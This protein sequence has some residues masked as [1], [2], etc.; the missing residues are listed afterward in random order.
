MLT[1]LRIQGFKSWRDTGDLRLAPITAIFGPNS[2]GKSSILQFLLMLKQTVESTDNGTPLNLGDDRSLVDLGVFETVLHRPPDGSP[3]SLNSNRELSFSIDYDALIARRVSQGT[4]FTWSAQTSA[5]LSMDA[6]GAPYLKAFR[7]SWGGTSCIV[8]RSVENNR[9]HPFH[10]QIASEI[11]ERLN[12][13]IMGL[14]EVIK[15]YNL[16]SSST[17]R[18]ERHTYHEFSGVVRSFE[19]TFRDLHYLGPLRD[20]PRRPYPWGGS[21]PS[22]LGSMG[23]HTVSAIL[24]DARTRIVSKAANDGDSPPRAPLETSVA[25]WL[26]KLG[27]ADEFNIDEVAK[28]TNLYRV[29]VRPVSSRNKVMVTDVGFGV[30]QVL[31]VLALAFFGNPDAVCLIEQP[32]LHLHPAVQSHLADLFIDAQESSNKQFI[33]ESHSEHLLLRFQRRIAEGRI[34]PED[35]ALYF[36]EM[37]DGESRISELK[38]DEYGNIANWPKDF[39]GDEFGE[40]AAITKAQMTRR[41]EQES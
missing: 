21:A 27:I 28:G 8:T 35:V 25:L 13:Y 2:S 29:W 6:L 20:R 7:H 16:L 10:L 18:L 17:E 30:S 11:V 33:I 23:E 31:P 36:C 15:F 24:A 12:P 14:N 5:Q 3:K 34:K 39:F 40:M 9:E 37:V 22:T 4:N 1:R 19:H 38:L 41:M 32:E 26:K